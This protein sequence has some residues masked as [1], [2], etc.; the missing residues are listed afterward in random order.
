MP[1]A[2]LAFP[3]RK[4]SFP[5]RQL[6]I[7]EKFSSFWVNIISLGAKIQNPRYSPSGRKENTGGEERKRRN[8]LN[9]SHCIQR[10]PRVLKLSN[11]EVSSR[12]LGRQHLYDSTT[13]RK[14]N[15]PSQLSWC[16]RSAFARTL[17]VSAR[18]DVLA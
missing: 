14:L 8:N 6:Q 12:T 9:S 10:H 7:V 5:F 3:K 13:E 16:E 15:C 4:H 11:R 2:V 1:K 18:A 17:C